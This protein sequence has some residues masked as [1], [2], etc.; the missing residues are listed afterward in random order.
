MREVESGQEEAHQDRQG[1]GQHGRG[2]PPGCEGD[3]LGVVTQGCHDVEAGMPARLALDYDQ[4]YRDGDQDQRDLG[5]ALA[6]AQ[7]IP[8]PV[9]RRREGM[10]A[11]VL[12]GAEIGQSLEKCQHH[13]GCDGRACQRQGDAPKGPP[14]AMPQ[15]TT[16]L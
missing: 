13:A 6:V 15:D 16:G 12:H 8:G 7:P 9:D 11:V 2:R 5:R 4:Q 14:R 1:A 10:D 3:R